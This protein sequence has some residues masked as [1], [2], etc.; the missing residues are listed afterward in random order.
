M[1]IYI[2][3]KKEFEFDEFNYNG[4]LL[5]LIRDSGQIII[6]NISGKELDRIDLS[7]IDY[8]KIENRSL[9]ENDY[10]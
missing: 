8:L 9:E 4:V 7:N 1:N 10:R 6:Y 3:L 2:K 5:D